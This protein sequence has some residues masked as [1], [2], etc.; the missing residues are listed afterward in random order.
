MRVLMRSASL[1]L[2]AA[3][4]VITSHAQANA[5]LVARIGTVEVQRGNAWM[6]VL[7]GEPINTGERLRTAIGSSA[8]LELGPGKVITLHQSTEIEVGESNGAPTVR[9]ESGNMKVVAEQDIQVSAKDTTLQ[10]AEKPLDMEVGYQVD[11]LNLTVITGAVT[12]GPITIR[13]TEDSAKRSYVAD[14]RRAAYGN[15]VVQPNSF[16]FYPYVFYGNPGNLVVT[17]PSPSNPYSGIMPG[18]I[19]PPMTDPLRPPVHYPIN[20]FPQRPPQ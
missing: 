9:L 15:I 5:R 3:I 13:G 11:R 12:T 16:Y 14:S 7:P 18:Q 8:A 20:P 17:Q 10:S 1:I 6:P 19:V 4:G 2:V